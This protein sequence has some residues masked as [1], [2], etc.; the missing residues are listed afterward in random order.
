MASIATISNHYQFNSRDQSTDIA[1]YDDIRDRIKNT[2]HYTDA[3][4]GR[5]IE[6]LRKEGFFERTLVV[7][8]ADHGYNLGE[9]TPAG[10]RNGF[11]ESTW[12]PLIMYGAH[13]R[14]PKGQHDQLVA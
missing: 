4:I 1:G 5:M 12:S 10:Q 14:L 13:P 3:V 9:H 2:T 8:F 6:R 7:V 11:H